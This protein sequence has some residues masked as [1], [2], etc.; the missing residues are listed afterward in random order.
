MAQD[1]PSLFPQWAIDPPAAPPTTITEPTTPQK[2]S[3]WQPSG[4]AEFPD[5]KP[6]RQIMNWLQNLFY[7]WIVWLDAATFRWLKFGQDQALPGIPADRPSIGAG[8]VIAA[9]DFT[10]TVIESGYQ[11][12]PISPPLGFVYTALQDTYWDLRRDQTWIDTPVPNGNPA[13]AVAA[14]SIRCYM[15]ET[16]AADR[17]AVTDFRNLQPD[18][19][20]MRLGEDLLSNE[21]DA[22]K[23]RVTMNRAQ[24]TVET[25][26]LFYESDGNEAINNTIVRIYG[27][28]A[29]FSDLVFTFGAA[30]NATTGMW[31]PDA[32]AGP[33]TLWKFEI[34][35][36]T[37]ATN[38][39]F[40][41]AATAPFADADWL[42]DGSTQGATLTMPGLLQLGTALDGTGAGGATEAESAR[43]RVDRIANGINERTLI[44]EGRGVGGTANPIRIYHTDTA[45]AALGYGFEICVGCLWVKSAN[46][47]RDD[48][49]PATDKYK[50]DI[51]DGGIR[52]LRHDDA[53]GSAWA[54]TIAATTWSALLFFSAGAG[55]QLTTNA[56]T[57]GILTGNTVLSL[58]DVTATEK[59]VGKRL[60]LTTVAPGAPEQHTQYS[61]L[62][63]KAW[64]KILTDGVGGFTT[65][66]LVGCT[67]AIVG[68]NIEITLARA[69]DSS[70]YAVIPGTTTAN[71]TSVYSILSAT[72]FTISVSEPTTFPP[73]RNL[74]TTSR[75]VSFHVMGQHA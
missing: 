9:G 36:G 35:A 29:S 19:R 72:V 1:R 41:V 13:P 55:L 64:G 62:I 12:G 5:G 73:V 43:L 28:N 2:D 42:F 44:Y 18:F 58:G 21:D 6:V 30:W 34:G 16:D 26:T 11:I 15:V 4:S 40:F 37:F 45:T 51:T 14:D 25:Y 8:L 32:A 52:V 22:V 10:A 59:L 70:D 33:I 48:L 74:S 53:D 54:D 23:P 38:S 71:E 39:K 50:I 65:S 24:S 75:E 68:S 7:Q 31:D 49:T 69:M 46:E 47:W 27:R 20:D 61:D 67:A 56:Q 57:T 60:R 63:A 3:G 66:R 17:T